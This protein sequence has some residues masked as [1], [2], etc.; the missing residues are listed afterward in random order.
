M[1]PV[2]PVVGVPAEMDPPPEVHRRC[3]AARRVLE[4][5]RANTM[6]DFAPPS[7]RLSLPSVRI[8]QP[9]PLENDNGRSFFVRQGA[10]PHRHPVLAAGAR[11]PDRLVEVVSDRR[12]GVGMK[13][14]F[15]PAVMR[16]MI[17]TPTTPW[18]PSIAGR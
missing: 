16:S 11:G 5:G 9:N 2:L 10:R 18:F 3:F 12:G 6:P 7:G 15:V 14:V 4:V 1:Q 13:G 8:L 17:S